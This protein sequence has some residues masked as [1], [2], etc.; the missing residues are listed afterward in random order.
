MATR[1][2]AAPVSK[3]TQRLPQWFQTLTLVVMAALAILGVLHSALHLIQ[4]E[5]LFATSAMFQ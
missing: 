4:D 1:T 2:A 5:H 3:R